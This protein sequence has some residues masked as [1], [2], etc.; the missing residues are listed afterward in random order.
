MVEKRPSPSR[1]SSMPTTGGE[2][3]RSLHLWNRASPRLGSQRSID[4]RKITPSL[5]RDIGQVSGSLSLLG[6]G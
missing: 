3:N 2:T 1:K 5:A 4:L 6:G